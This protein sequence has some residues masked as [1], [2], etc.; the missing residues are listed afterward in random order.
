MARVESRHTPVKDLHVSAA[1]LPPSRHR[2]RPVVLALVLFAA[3]TAARFAVPNPIEAVGFLY[4]VPISMVA[5]EYGWRGGVL[6]A[7]IAFGLAVVWALAEDVPLGALGYGVRA[8]TFAFIGAVVGLQDE[9]RRRLERE[10]EALVAELRRLATH[11]QL[12]GLPNRRAWDDRLALELRRSARSNEPLTVAAIDLDKLKHVNDT[13]GHERGDLMLRTCS[14]VWAGAIRSTDFLAR[15]GG[16]EF[17]VLLPNCRPA[18]AELVASRMFDE[19]PPGHGFSIGIARWDGAEA[20]VDLVRRADHALYAV[21]A[22][23]GNSARAA[24]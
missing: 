7:A 17:V 8:S 5:V 12:T 4:V 2:A 14:A 23:G 22:E 15:I 3:I 9:L 20:P 6:A 24:A 19:M 13:Q 10:R 18:E 21:K 11:D 1:A 16:D